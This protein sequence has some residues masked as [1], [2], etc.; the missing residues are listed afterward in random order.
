MD[1]LER[2]EGAG[3]T[4]RCAATGEICHEAALIRFVADPEGGLHPDPAAKA[5]GRGVWV[6]ATRDAVSL[7]VKKNAFAKSLKRPVRPDADLPDRVRLALR[8]RCLQAL[9]IGRRGGHVIAGFDQVDAAL[10]RDRPGWRIEAADGAADGRRKLDGL[11]RRWDDHP[12]GPPPTAACFTGAE[13]G[14]ALGR[15]VVIHA[16]LPSGRFAESWAVEIG[17]LAGFEPLLPAE[18]GHAD[19]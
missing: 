7:A 10:R 18:W 13:L 9:S 16:L 19:P 4:R 8:A 15:D 2:R 12:A 1:R 11:A 6:R 17:R 14:M 5:P 3:R